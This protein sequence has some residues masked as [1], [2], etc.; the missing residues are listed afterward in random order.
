MRWE[1]EMMEK[2]KNKLDETVK[3]KKIMEITENDIRDG[4]KGCNYERISLRSISGLLVRL[5]CIR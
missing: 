5:I 2:I 3:N 4:S 1:G